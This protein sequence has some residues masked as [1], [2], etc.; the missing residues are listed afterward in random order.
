MPAPG[1][2][3]AVAGKAWKTIFVSSAALPSSRVLLHSQVAPFRWRCMGAGVPFSSAG[4]SVGQAAEV[5]VG[6]TGG[7]CAVDVLATPGDFVS[8]TFRF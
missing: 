7:F 8:A 1:M 5:W 6:W 2:S 4:N 3:G